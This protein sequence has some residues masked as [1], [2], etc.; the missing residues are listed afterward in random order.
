VLVVATV[1]F[2]K[3]ESVEFCRFFDSRAVSW[4]LSV[5]GCTVRGDVDNAGRLAAMEGDK[6]HIPVFSC[7]VTTIFSNVWGGRCLEV[8]K[9]LECSSPL[10]EWAFD[11]GGHEPL[12]LL[13]LSDEGEFDNDES[14]LD[15]L[16]GKSTGPTHNDSRDHMRQLMFSNRGPS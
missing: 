7:I 11:T 13:L 5:S 3:H 16:G 2:D 1:V 14:P 8:D 4:L 9:E 10:K 15:R 12:S 6:G